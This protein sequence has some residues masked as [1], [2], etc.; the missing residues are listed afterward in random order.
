LLEYQAGPSQPQKVPSAFLSSRLVGDLS[1]GVT[2]SP[3]CDPSYHQH[4]DPRLYK[5]TPLPSP[6]SPKIYQRSHHPPLPPSLGTV[7]NCA[8]S[9]ESLGQPPAPNASKPVTP[10]IA[11]L[12]IISP[13]QDGTRRNPPPSAPPQVLQ[14]SQSKISPSRKEPLW[15]V[16]VTPP[17]NI[18]TPGNSTPLFR[19]LHFCSFKPQCHTLNATSPRAVVPEQDP[20]PSF[21]VSYKF[22]LSLPRSS[23]IC[24]RASAL[25]PRGDMSFRCQPKSKLL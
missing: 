17:E 14:K 12:D 7:P 20:F 25:T 23:W 21:T 22:L 24:L 3:H 19:S 15:K 13:P 6:T 5:F 9:C 4:S 8:L 10:V 11:N 18:V 2:S 16:H 1:K